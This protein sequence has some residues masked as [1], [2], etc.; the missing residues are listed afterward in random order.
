MSK[1]VDSVALLPSRHTSKKLVSQK[2][3]VTR[4][5]VVQ[6]ASLSVPH[7]AQGPRLCSPR[8][9]EAAARDDDEPWKCDCAVLS[10]EGNE[11]QTRLCQCEP[12]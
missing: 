10:A 8:V 4:V 5:L 6:M 1:V 12:Q 7:A 3:D 11:M 9:P 2:A